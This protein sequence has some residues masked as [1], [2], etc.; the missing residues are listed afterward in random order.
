MRAIVRQTPLKLKSNSINRV[1]NYPFE[2]TAV[3]SA[4]PPTAPFLIRILYT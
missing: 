4:I 2:R 3:R 1:G